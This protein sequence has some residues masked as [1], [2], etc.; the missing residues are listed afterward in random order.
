M[1]PVVM[2][3]PGCWSAAP[4]GTHQLPNRVERG[5]YI[6]HI[7]LGKDQDHQMIKIRIKLQTAVLRRGIVGISSV[8]S[9]R[10]RKAI[11]I[12]I[13]YAQLFCV[14]MAEQ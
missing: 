5:R 7:L 12:C 14:A 8:C 2:Q 13:T 11:H 4:R 6:Q 10:M 1:G 3:G 9:V